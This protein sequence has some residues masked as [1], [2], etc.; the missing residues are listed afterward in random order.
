MKVYAKGIIINAAGE[1]LLVRANTEGE[2]LEAELQLPTVEVG[3]YDA[4]LIKLQRYVKE[5]LQCEK[6]DFVVENMGTVQTAVG[7]EYR[8]YMQYTGASHRTAQAE[9]V[10]LS[11]LPE[12]FQTVVTQ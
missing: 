3:E 6:E 4:P 9:F 12:E 1:L 8:I 7:V 2:Q 11:E 10:Q 5:L